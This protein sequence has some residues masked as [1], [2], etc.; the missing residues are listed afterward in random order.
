MRDR[1]LAVQMDREVSRLA[2]ER[3]KPHRCPHCGVGHKTARGVE[4]HSRTCLRGAPEGHGHSGGGLTLKGW[5]DHCRCG[6]DT[7]PAD[8]DRVTKRAL[9]EHFDAATTRS[10]T[11]G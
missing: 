9:R 8:S 4:Q 11:N 10:A 7:P 3:E 6:W 2:D 1:R 5:V